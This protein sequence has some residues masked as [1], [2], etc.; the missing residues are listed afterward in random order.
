MSIQI[1]HI[2][3]DKAATR[4]EQWGFTLWEFIIGNLW[5]IIGILVILAIFLYARSY[6][7]RNENNGTR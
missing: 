6:F 4:E 5:Y 2:P 3:Q 7:K 1:E